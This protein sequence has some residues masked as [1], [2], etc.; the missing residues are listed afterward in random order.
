[1]ADPTNTE[2]RSD[3]VRLRAEGHGNAAIAAKL[4]VSRQRVHQ[5]LGPSEAGRC[6]KCGQRMPKPKR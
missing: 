4:G 3:A 1:M 5:I 6:S 2:T